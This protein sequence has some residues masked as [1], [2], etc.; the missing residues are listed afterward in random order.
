MEN[1]IFEVKEK[2]KH[3]SQEDII[4]IKTKKKSA[5]FSNS[6]GDKTPT[7]KQKKKKK[8][9]VR[10]SQVNAYKFESKNRMRKPARLNLSTVV[11]STNLRRYI[12][13]VS[14]TSDE[15]KIVSTEKS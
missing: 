14:T 9:F 2:E 10:T 4:K 7:T 11:K 12:H 8:S 6:R 15:D 5:F 1:V 3:F 13:I